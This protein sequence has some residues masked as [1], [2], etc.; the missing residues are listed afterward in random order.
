MFGRRQLN[1]HILDEAADPLVHK[2]GHLQV[3]LLIEGFDLEFLYKNQE[4][5]YEN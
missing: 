4:D 3:I 2:I 1:K 5:K